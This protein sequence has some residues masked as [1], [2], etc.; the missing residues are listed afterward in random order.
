MGSDALSVG[1]VVTALFPV[2]DP[3]GHEQE[4]YRPAVV[5]GVPAFVGSPRFP[6]LLLAPLTTDRDQGWAR[7]SPALYPRLAEGTTGLRSPSLCLLDQA[8]ALSIER[9]RTYRGA[10]SGE[11]Y[12]PIREGLK[13]IFSR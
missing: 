12:E 10:L 3:V 7:S 1:D 6:V 8:Q 2:H 11:E 13:R 5:V 9:L 4:G